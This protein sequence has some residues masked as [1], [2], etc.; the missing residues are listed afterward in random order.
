MEKDRKLVLI[1]LAGVLLVAILARVALALWLGDLAE[2]IS[3]A[4]DQVSYDTLAQRLLAGRGFSFPV[5]WYPFTNADEPTA[6]WSFLYTLYLAGVYALFGHHPLAARLLQVLIS[7][8]NLW[9]AYRLGRRLF[10]EWAGVAAAGLTAAYASLIFF[11]AVLMTQT[12]YILAVLAVCDVALSLVEKPTR[13]RWL[14][15]GF[16]IGVGALLR[17]TLLLF[18][19]IL[20]VWL[21]WVISL[22]A[23]HDRQPLRTFAPQPFTVI[24]RSSLVIFS[25]MLDRKSVV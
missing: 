3:G 17:Q 5:A 16:I 11:N 7:G 15:L 8:L 12:F 20:F 22:H 9:L 23:A 13:L 1:L 19:P 10:G 18:A 6:H 4:Y 14:L 25:G 2:P 21:A 24:R